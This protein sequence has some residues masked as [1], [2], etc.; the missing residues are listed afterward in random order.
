[1]TPHA[2]ELAGRTEDAA[3]AWAELGCPYEAAMALAHADRPR[4]LR[5]A[6]A[7][8]RNLEARPAAAIVT[9]RLRERGIRD[10]PREPRAATRGNP[11]GLTP[12]ELEVLIQVA[13]GLRNAEIAERLFVSEKTVDHHVSAILRKLRVP[14]RGRAA[15]EAARL[16]LIPIDR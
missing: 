10:L 13:A 14:S 1:V 2:L 5:R 6:L 11:A 16:G 7:D 8:L 12:R 9:R 15:A 3:L 4:P